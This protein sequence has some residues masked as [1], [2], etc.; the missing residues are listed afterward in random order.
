MCWV[1]DYPFSLLFLLFRW[2][3]KDRWLELWTGWAK[4]HSTVD[5]LKVGRGGEYAGYWKIALYKKFSFN[6]F[7]FFFSQHC[8][9]VLD[10]RCRF[11]DLV[12]KEV[13]FFS[14]K[15]KKKIKPL[16][17]SFF[18]SLENLRVC[19]IPMFFHLKF[20]LPIKYSIL[21]FFMFYCFSTLQ[22]FNW[23]FSHTS[24]CKEA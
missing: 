17:M 23:T 21:G 15:T 18:L 8:C 9:V 24:G 14:G 16:W 3:V 4:E 6:L 1:I 13:V 10:L 20:T 5:H 22:R 7:F 12:L 11:Y 19:Y 2:L